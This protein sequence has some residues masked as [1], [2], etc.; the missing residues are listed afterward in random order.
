[1]KRLGR[2]YSYRP[3]LVFRSRFAPRGRAFR[4]RGAPPPRVAP[5]GR[6]CPRK[7]PPP[8]WAR[9]SRTPPPPPRAQPRLG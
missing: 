2:S 8:R 7:A 5:S 6:P 1:M 3:T 4:Q 9:R